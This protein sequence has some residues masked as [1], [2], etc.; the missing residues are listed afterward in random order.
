[1][2]NL[3]KLVA[4]LATVAFAGM[5]FAP[6]EDMPTGETYHPELSQSQME[7]LQGGGVA[8]PTGRNSS[9]P[10]LNSGATMPN[11]NS[12]AADMLSKGGG[13][14]GSSAELSLK[15]ADA[16]QGKPVPNKGANFMFAGLFIIIGLALVMGVRAYLDKTVPEMPTSKR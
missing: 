4:I 3:R 6:I 5:C 9:A 1:M 11:S 8:D 2:K 14:A 12:N 13:V 16:D 15:Q 10:D 7:Q